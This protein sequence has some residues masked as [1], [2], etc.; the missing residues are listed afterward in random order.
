MSRN[1]VKTAGLTGALPARPGDAP[2]S[3]AGGVVNVMSVDVEEWFQVT[4]FEKVIPRASWD[5]CPP[6][7]AEVLPRLLDIF[8]R[9]HV[10]ATF[11][12]LGWIA[13][14]YPGLVRRI[15]DE[16]HEVASHGYDHRL[17][18]VMTRGEFRADLG[19]SRDILQQV[20][21]RA[22][23][24]YR[25]PSYSFP[26]G[27]EWIFDEIARAG[28][29]FDS[30]VFPWCGRSDPSLCRSR[31]P[32]TVERDGR[33]LTE[34]PLSIVTLWGRN[35][36]I[37]G[38]AFF[39]MLPYGIV[40]RGV[41]ELNEA[42]QPAIMYFHPWEFDPGQPR[43]AAASPLSKFR[44]YANIGRNE[45]KLGRLVEAFRFASFRDVFWNGA[46]GRYDIVP[47]V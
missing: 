10:R 20:L 8:M 9:H 17:V 39:R 3:A 19:R 15:S 45:A 14:R 34:Y 21:G 37:A 28:Y 35:W 29:L 46:L 6:R 18:R 40:A 24:G 42:R 36:P 44:H 27:A 1:G 23:H 25:A 7:V 13:E 2:L 11:F 4:N 41:R 32:F 30:S 43:V 22:V 26:K 16:G 31:Q 12:V 38:G 33:T 5:D 47:Q